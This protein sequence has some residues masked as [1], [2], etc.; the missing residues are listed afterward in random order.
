MDPSKQHSINRMGPNLNQLYKNAW[1]LAQT[2][3]LS[4]SLK[5]RTITVLFFRIYEGIYQVPNQ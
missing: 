3:T 1:Y 2:M 4:Q 5:N